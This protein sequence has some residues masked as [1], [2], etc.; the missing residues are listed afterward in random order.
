MTDRIVLVEWEDT[1]ASHGWQTKADDE[2]APA[3]I[4]SVGF[5]LEDSERGVNIMESFT[6][7][8]T[9]AEKNHGCNNFIPRSAIRKVTE[10]GPV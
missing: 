10:L 1:A 9:A 6:V 3:M 4:R 2:I 8:M 5:V 7:S